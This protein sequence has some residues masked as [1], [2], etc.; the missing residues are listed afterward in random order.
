[1][2]TLLQIWGFFTEKKHRMAESWLYFFSHL[3][4]KCHLCRKFV[5]FSLKKPHDG[6]IL[7]LLLKLN[8][9]VQFFNQFGSN[10]HQPCNF[11]H[12]SHGFFQ[13]F[14]FF[15]LFHAYNSKLLF[16][17]FFNQFGSNFTSLLI[18]EIHHIPIFKID[19]F[20]SVS[21]L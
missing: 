2:S 16:W 19:F 14:P 8:L 3:D 20:F 11:W 15:S 9:S 21:R 7:T 18:F 6:R 10:F 13:N 4:I 17:P 1:M 12:R 5:F